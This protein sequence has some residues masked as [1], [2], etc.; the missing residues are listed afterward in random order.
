MK[1][2]NLCQQERI[3][4]LEAM[5]DKSAGHIA[6]FN[7]INSQKKVTRDALSYVAEIKR[8][9]SVTQES[10]ES[11]DQVT[12][13]EKRQEETQQLRDKKLMQL[14]SKSEIPK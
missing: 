10:T 6:M 3:A 4:A 5:L 11:I 8:D 9:P 12:H 2:A 14:L 13:Q 1:A 7:N